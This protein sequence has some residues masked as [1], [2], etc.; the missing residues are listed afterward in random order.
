MG[1]G[2]HGNTKGTG[3]TKVGKLQVVSLINEQVL[4]LEIA[5]ENP[6]GVAIKQSRVE[7][8]SKF[9]W[10]IESAHRAVVKDRLNA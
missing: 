5:V 2:S 7:L 3:Q 9:L 1:I 6:V 10:N 8:V 4:G